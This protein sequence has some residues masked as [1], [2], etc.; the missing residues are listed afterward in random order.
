MRGTVK[1][2]NAWIGMEYSIEIKFMAWNG[3]TWSG[4]ALYGDAG[5]DNV[6]CGE[7]W[8]GMRRL[9]EIR[10]WHG[11]ICHGDAG[12]RVVRL[13]L[14]RQGLGSFI[15]ISFMAWPGHVG[16]G[17]A[18]LGDV[19]CGD[20]RRGLTGRGEVWDVLLKIKFMAG[21]CSARYGDVWQRGAW[22]VLQQ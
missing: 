17:G 1:H 9:I 14:V 18:R 6:G 16:C 7:M 20:V 21:Y 11:K 4:E 19:R 22:D 15:K 2:G 12:W 5:H 3:E 10:F 13:S 8:R